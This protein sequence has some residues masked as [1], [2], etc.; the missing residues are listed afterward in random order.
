MKTI[1]M[2]ASNMFVVE[3]EPGD[4]TRYS[5]FVIVDH[6]GYKFVPNKSTFTF[7]Q[8]INKWNVLDVIATREVANP[9]VDELAARYNCNPCTV[10]ECIRTIQ[11]LGVDN[12]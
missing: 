3:S 11:E 4:A 9:I 2:S 5:Y 6:D 8:V 12:G 10:L 7:P 1:E